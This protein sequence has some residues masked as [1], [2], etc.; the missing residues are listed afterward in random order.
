MNDLEDTTIRQ[1]TKPSVRV[2]LSHRQLDNVW[3]RASTH[4]MNNIYWIQEMAARYI[5]IRKYNKKA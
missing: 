1:I 4:S 3:S 5:Y 2:N